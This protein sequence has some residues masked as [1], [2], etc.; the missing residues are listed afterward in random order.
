MKVGGLDTL[1]SLPT[2]LKS[3]RIEFAEAQVLRLAFRTSWSEHSFIFWSSR[4]DVPSEDQYGLARLGF[5][6]FHFSH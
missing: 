5:H 4:F 1:S 6:G 2:L 3:C